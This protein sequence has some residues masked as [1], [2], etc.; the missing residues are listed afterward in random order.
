MLKGPQSAEGD[1]S[2]QGAGTGP[3]PEA[4]RRTAAG[5]VLKVMSSPA[6]LPRPGGGPQSAEGEIQPCKPAASGHFGAQAVTEAGARHLV[7][8]RDILSRPVTSCHG[9]RRSRW[10]SCVTSCLAHAAGPP[11]RHALGSPSP[12][13]GSKDLIERPGSGQACARLAAQTG[14]L[15]VRAGVRPRIAGRSPTT[16]SCRAE[17][18]STEI[19]VGMGCEAR[20]R[21]TQR[22]WQHASAD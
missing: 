3:P 14:G 2:P 12:P 17:A 19:R 13:P 8:A 6:R 18:N 1:A 9:P 10:V 11:T 7:T 20:D 5:K 15:C 4:G 22:N 16:V 21:A